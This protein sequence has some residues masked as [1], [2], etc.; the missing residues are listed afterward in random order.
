MTAPAL[1]DYQSNLLVAVRE[2]YRQGHRRILIQAATGS[3]KTVVASE[4]IRGC[5]EKGTHCAFVA[6]RREIV[7]QTSQTLD[8]FG[9]RHGLIMSGELPTSKFV[10][11]C[12]V[13]TLASWMKRGKIKPFWHGGLLIIDECHRSLAKSYTDLIPEG[14]RDTLLIGLSATPARSDGRGLGDLYDVMI[15]AP[16][17]GELIEHGHLVPPVYYAPTDIDL[18]DLSVRM[19]DYVDKE[20]AEKMDRPKLIGDVV[21]NWGRV[22]ADRKTVVFASGVQHSIHLSEAFKAAGIAA[23]HLDGKTTKDD[24]EEILAG[25]RKGD[26]QVL[27]NCQV[28]T[29]GWDQPDVSACVLAKPTKSIGLYLQMLGRVL[30]PFE[31]KTDAIIM[32][33]G[34]CVK[35]HGFAHE[36][37]DWSLDPDQKQANET[38]ERRKKEG[39][40]P[41][42]CDECFATFTGARICPKCGTPIKIKGK[43][44]VFLEGDLGLVDADNIARK[45]GYTKEEKQHWYQQLKY[46]QEREGYA[47]GW[48]AHKY[49]AKFD[50]WPS[51]M[52]DLGPRRCGPA[53]YAF[54][55]SQQNKYRREKRK[56]AA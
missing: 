14:D 24:R 23:A 11:V 37:T 41:I 52:R 53:V 34:G 33:H 31:G 17:V 18:D 2:A 38:Q 20:L 8:K 16:S 5:D 1:R 50:V 45:S 42:V 56:G 36:F 10:Q 30:R 12:S 35:E 13:Q 6:H 44:I 22:C 40:K 15:Q 48:L 3:G 21:E 32:D 25:F 54:L 19:G 26:I 46:V 7:F 43:G 51:G 4:I 29:E 27:T 39:G 47:A 49:R 28:L 55:K 9:V